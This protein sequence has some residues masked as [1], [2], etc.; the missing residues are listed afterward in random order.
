MTD[1]SDKAQSIPRLESISIFAFLEGVSQPAGADESA[2]NEHLLEVEDF[3]LSH[4]NFTDRK[5]YRSCPTSTRADVHRILENRGSVLS[6]SSDTSNEDQ[7]D[8]EEYVD[9]FNTVDIIFRFFFPPDSEVVTMGKFWG[10][11]KVLIVVSIKHGIFS[12][13]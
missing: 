12:S 9:M 2:L 4:A 5:A 10:A 13:L 6:Q 7:L 3:L 11:V 1:T 8:Y